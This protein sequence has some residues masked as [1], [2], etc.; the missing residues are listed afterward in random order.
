M[1]GKKLDRIPSTSIKEINLNFLCRLAT[2]WKNLVFRSP[3]LSHKAL[4]FYLHEISSNRIFVFVLSEILFQVSPFDGYICA[5]SYI[6]F[7]AIKPCS[8]LVS[9]EILEM[10]TKNIPNHCSKNNVQDKRPDRRHWP[11]LIM[12]F[13]IYKCWS[14]QKPECTQHP[15]Q[16]QINKNWLHH[17]TEV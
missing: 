15:A 10:R 6:V 5:K 1:A 12:T 8:F 9:S 11:D 16:L 13:I 14:N 2:L 4:D 17:I 7:S 3:A